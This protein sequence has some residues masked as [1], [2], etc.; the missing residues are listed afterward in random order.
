[1]G[2]ELNGI[3]WSC[4]SKEVESKIENLPKE[5]NLSL[6]STRF[7]NILTTITSFEELL[8][9]DKTFTIPHQI[10]NHW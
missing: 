7:N 9:K 5:P 8:G 3:D 1:M 6:R 10:L 2:T 4:F